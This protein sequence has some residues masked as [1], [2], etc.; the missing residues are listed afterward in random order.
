MEHSPSWDANRFSISQEIN[1]IL[2]KPKIYY[3]IQ[4]CP[5][6]GPILNHLDPVHTTHLTSW[7]SILIL[8]SHLRVDLSSSLF[9]SGLPTET[10]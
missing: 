1:P 6:P 7:R 8:S 2:W 9:P 4:K 5:P 10:L 3:G